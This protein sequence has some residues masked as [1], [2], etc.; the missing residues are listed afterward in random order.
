MTVQELQERVGAIARQVGFDAELSN[1]E[2]LMWAQTE[3]SEA[4][5]E[6]RRARLAVD[7]ISFQSDGKPVGTPIEIADAIITLCHLADRNGIDLQSA[8]EIK[9]AWNAQ[10]PRLHGYDLG[11]LRLKARA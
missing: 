9:L 7:E 5:T 11:Q 1:L 2:L 10:R 8:I 3:L 6:L 4:F